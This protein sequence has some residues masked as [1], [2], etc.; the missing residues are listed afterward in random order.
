[1]DPQLAYDLTGQ[2]LDHLGIFKSITISFLIY[3][4]TAFQKVVH[5][6]VYCFGRQ[7]HLPIEIFILQ[8]TSQ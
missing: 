5:K 6:S 8:V 3:G 7:I 2:I 1:M 4:L